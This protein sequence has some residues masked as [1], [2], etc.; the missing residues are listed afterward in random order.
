MSLQGPYWAAQYSSILEE[1]E[2]SAQSFPVIHQAFL[3]T[4]HVPGAEP[5][6]MDSTKLNV[7][8]WILKT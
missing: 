1:A 4:F 3:R 8:I 6:T 7:T 5:H 2:G